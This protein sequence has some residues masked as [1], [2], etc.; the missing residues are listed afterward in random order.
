MKTESCESQ[1]TDQMQLQ[2]SQPSV[3]SSEA[4]GSSSETGD[5][6]LVDILRSDQLASCPILVTTRP[7]RAVEIRSD[8]DLMKLYTF[9]HIEGFSRENLSVYIHKYFPKNDDKANQLIQFIGGNDVLSENM[10]HYPI[11][12][13]ML[14][15]MWK[16]LDKQKLKKMKSLKTFSQ[17]FKEMIAFLKE[18]YAQKEVKKVGSPSLIAHL[19]KIDEDLVPIAK[20]ALNG[21]LENTLIFSEDD[22]EIC[23]ESKDTACRVGILSQEERIATTNT[24]THERHSHVQLPVFFPHKLFQEYMA[25]V[26]LASLYESDPNEFNRLMEQVVLPR[27]K[28]FRY[29]LY[30]TVSQ[31]KSIASH[32]MKSMLRK[33]YRNIPFIVD[34]AFESLDPDVAALVKDRDSS[35]ETVLIVDTPM[36]AHTVAGYAFI[37]PYLVKLWIQRNCGPSV[38]LDVAEMICSIPSLMVVSLQGEFHHCFFAT[39]A[40]KGKESKVKTLELNYVKCPT[41]ASLHHLVEAL[42]SMPNLTDLILGMYLNEEF[43]S[44]LKAQASS[45]QVKTLEL[46]NVGFPTPASS[47]LVETLC[48]MP[49]LTDLTLPMDLDEEFYCTL[50]ANAS[51]IQVKTLKLHAV[52]FPTPASSQLLA[53]ALCYMPNLSDLTLETDLNEEPEEFLSSLKTHASSIQGCFPQIR[54]GN[55]RF[56]GIAQDDLN[57]FLHTLSSLCD[58]DDSSISDGSNDSDV[59]SVSDGS[60]DS[61]GLADLANISVTTDVQSPRRTSPPSDHPQQQ[62]MGDVHSPRRTIPS[63]DHPQQH[64]GNTSDAVCQFSQTHREGSSSQSRPYKRQAPSTQSRVPQDDPEIPGKQ[65]KV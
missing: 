56:N 26:H 1:P 50:K 41:S 25:G 48:Y 12:V 14:C 43:F 33:V 24:D 59:L 4:C 13:A 28:E 11:Y 15:L 27:Y 2:P 23:P 51:S 57:S 40:M 21:L 22:F 29:L 10:A 16:E 38:S 53:E 54:K 52:R 32:V 18:H 42:C 46:Y 61:D 65:S 30:F 31:N 49:N 44:S 5:I 64:V 39:L 63:S 34:V 58:S 17:I 8:G 19:K 60:N 6:G 9:I 37:G 62:P 47:H 36:T 55:F 35:V 3:T 20:Q 45:I 7:W